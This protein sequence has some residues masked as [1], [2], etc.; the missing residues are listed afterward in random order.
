[1]G[2]FSIDTIFSKEEIEEYKKKNYD[3]KK[4]M[5]RVVYW[6]INRLNSDYN[7]VSRNLDKIINWSCIIY[8]KENTLNSKN[9]FMLFNQFFNQYIRKRYS[10]D[11]SFYN[12]MILLDMYL[13]KLY[14]CDKVYLITDYYMKNS[15]T[16]SNYFNDKTT[17]DIFSEVL[18]KNNYNK[19][20]TIDW[21]DIYGNDY[22]MKDNV[23]NHY[24]E[25]RV[26][27]DRM[28]WVMKL[29]KLNDFVNGNWE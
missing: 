18:K 12:L 19:R 17:N 13:T 1:M 11:Y 27:K 21:S 25:D 14:E 7:W 2:D 15:M 29:G 5:N 8:D 28:F 20:D 16:L 3:S 23:L 24:L 26:W 9:K 10:L 4:D 22:D 6:N